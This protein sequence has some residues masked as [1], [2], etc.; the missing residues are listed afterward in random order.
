MFT[1]PV[2]VTLIVGQV[3]DSLSV[4][5][6]VGGSLASSLQGVP[7]STQD[8]DLVAALLPSHVGPL[9]FALEG[10]FHL[11]ESAIID[12]IRRRACFNL[13]HLE[14]L[15]K[16]DVFVPKGDP[17]GRLQLARRRY[18]TL[19]DGARLP[20]SSPEDVILQKLDWYRRGGA[21]AERQWRDIAGVLLVSGPQLD[22]AYLRETAAEAGIGDLLER[23]LRG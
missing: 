19:D 14:T 12:A 10:V 9:V 5:W 1:E 4:P 3:L 21:V 16:V 17:L 2:R 18:M 22:L 15:L 6:I 13:I 8:V 11:S 23:A 20:L 7:R